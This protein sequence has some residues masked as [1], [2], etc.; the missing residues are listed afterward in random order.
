[1]STK[2]NELAA[3]LKRFA[4]RIVIFARAMPNG[5]WPRGISAR[6]LRIATWPAPRTA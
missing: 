5:F 4:I 2:A 1:M 3:R 6:G